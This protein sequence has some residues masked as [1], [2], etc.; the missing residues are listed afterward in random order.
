MTLA[1]QQRLARFY[2]QIVGLARSGACDHW[3]RAFT[4]PAFPDSVTLR[5]PAGGYPFQELCDA[6]PTLSAGP[7]TS[8]APAFV[9]DRYAVEA[10][11]TQILERDGAIPHYGPLRRE[12][13]LA[14]QEADTCKIAPMHVDFVVQTAVFGKVIFA[15]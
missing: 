8:P 7:G 6:W 11:L 10:A 9:L 15:L 3:C 2:D 12:L 14:E 13:H 1:D 4:E 5:P